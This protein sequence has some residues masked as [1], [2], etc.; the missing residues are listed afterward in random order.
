MARKPRATAFA[1]YLV[2]FTGLT[3]ILVVFIAV[4]FGMDVLRRID[5]EVISTNRLRLENISELIETAILQ[6]G[7]RA[8]IETVTSPEISGTEFTDPYSCFL[9]HKELKLMVED[10]PS[11]ESLTIYVPGNG[12]LVSSSGI[13]YDTGNYL[14]SDFI[15]LLGRHDSIETNAWF[16]PRKKR[17]AGQPT[18]NQHEW[19]NTLT[20]VLA[21]RRRNNPA[22]PLYYSFVDISQSV[23]DRTIHPLSRN[24]N[25]VVVIFGPRGSIVASHNLSAAD[26]E[27]HTELVSGEQPGNIDAILESHFVAGKGVSVFSSRRIDWHYVLFSPRGTFFRVSRSLRD[28]I[29]RLS[30]ISILAG[31]G[32]SFFISKRLYGPL[33]RLLERIDEPISTGRVKNEYILITKTIDDLCT[34]IHNMENELAGSVLD[35]LLRR[36][37]HDLH[38][39]RLRS[40]L[41]HPRSVVL[42][43]KTRLREP[44]NNSVA[45]V[46]A[47]VE[48]LDHGFLLPIDRTSCVVIE[49]TREQESIIH[50]R[51]VHRVNEL[52]NKLRYP[53]TV[54]VGSVV[55]D[56]ELLPQAYSEAKQAQ[57][58][59]F[60]FPQDRLFYYSEIADRRH[61]RNELK[62]DELAGAIDNRS[63]AEI[64]GFFTTVSGM[65]ATG[66][67][68]HESIEDCVFAMISHLDIHK[69]RRSGDP[70]GLSFRRL[71]ADFFAKDDIHG[72]LEWLKRMM[73]DS[74]NVD[75]D[76]NDA[77][78]IINEIKHHIDTY[79]A[80][81][82]SLKYLADEFYMS[83]GYISFL[84]KQM[85]G[86]GIAEYISNVRLKNARYLLENE[87]L[88]VKQIA[89]QVGMHNISYF[90][91]KF[92][93]KYGLTPSRYRL[94]HR[95]E[96]SRI[97]AAKS[98][99]SS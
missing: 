41:P 36:G 99:P 22:L 75:R 73:V 17:V 20:C 25:E 9:L 31:I 35:Q 64:E 85:T 76:S 59:S 90:I 44:L 92:K 81:Q 80:D 6:P 48:S 62:I 4:L 10:Q 21:S 46:N 67:Y 50:H 87:H 3:V 5:A 96:I 38:E 57:W 86:V 70:Q 49:N 98:N 65:I 15:E 55:D 91:K 60:L 71:Y 33:R 84:F 24:P 19:Q 54:G 66:E 29:I 8:L 58:D 16:G 69:L 89:E 51:I 40:L 28:R 77:Q 52:E 88:Q 94:R 39:A 7:Y 14:D 61:L 79:H 93:A 56:Y 27:L 68:S 63:T 11:L 83:A 12:L 45:Q 32:L 1:R 78:S 23:I 47:F 26:R 53:I 95:H 74:V 37:A 2:S 43:L 18:E 42:Y 97:A 34:S 13:R 82:I 30:L 72:A